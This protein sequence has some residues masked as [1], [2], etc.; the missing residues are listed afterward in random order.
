MDR[1]AFLDYVSIAF[2]IINML[3]MSTTLIGIYLGKVVEANPSMVAL[4]GSYGFSGFVIVK[5]SISIL[6]VIPL[7]LKRL[8]KTNV[9]TKSVSV[10][11]GIASTY[12]F[13][14]YLIV[15][16]ENAILIL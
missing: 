8:W 13:V 3:D 1:L 16:I 4:L 11:F 15:V 7:S 12:L 10:G 5:I 14:Y 9:W 2:A 6:F